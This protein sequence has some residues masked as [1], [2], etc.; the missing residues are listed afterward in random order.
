VSLFAFGLAVSLVIVSPS[1]GWA[2]KSPYP[3]FT[4]E[5]LNDAMKAVGLAFG[6]MENAIAKKDFENAKDYLVRVRDQ[7]APSITIWRDRKMDDA[8][9]MLRDTLK[10]IDA[11]DAAMSSETVDA[12]AVG[13]LAREAATSCGTCHAKYREQDPT[14]KAYRLKPA[15]A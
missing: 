6:L 8:V 4:V 13:R 9:T 7:M 2:Q 12:D 5:H 11:L 3:I 14:T 10:K 15:P 1:V